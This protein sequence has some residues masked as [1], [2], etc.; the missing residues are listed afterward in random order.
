MKSIRRGYL[1]LGAVILVGVIAFLGFKEAYPRI[2]DAAG[3]RVANR[4]ARW[5]IGATTL[6]Q[7]IRSFPDV[8]RC[9]FRGAAECAP[10]TRQGSAVCV[11]DV[12]SNME[13]RLIF[14]LLSGRL[15]PASVK[16]K[17]FAEV[18]DRHLHDDHMTLPP[19]SSVIK[20]VQKGDISAYESRM[21]PSLLDV[22]PL[23]E[24]N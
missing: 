2:A 13:V 8:R 12:S 6:H 20:P 18:I 10:F 7:F 17:R 21:A 4:I 14:N 23:G 1:I 15:Y 3:E 24:A 19:L 11:I 9:E 22:I 5:P 16:T